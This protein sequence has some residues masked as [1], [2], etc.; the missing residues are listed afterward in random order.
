[1]VFMISK[2][3]L[4]LLFIPMLAACTLS[5][6]S[7]SS[8]NKNTGTITSSN[9]DVSM[10][11]VQNKTSY[12]YGEKINTGKDFDVSIIVG[13]E[14]PYSLSYDQSM[15]DGWY[16]SKLVDSNN[17]SVD[18]L[19]SPLTVAGNYQFTIKCSKYNDLFYEGQFKLL[20]GS[21]TDLAPD[22]ISVTLKRSN[23]NVGDS[24]TK[25]LITVKAT[26]NNY[27]GTETIDYNQDGVNGYAI[28]M[29]GWSFDKPLDEGLYTF[30]VS[31]RKVIKSVSF[32]VGEKELEKTSLIANYVDYTN[33]SVYEIDSMPSVGSPKALIVPVWLTD[34]NKYVSSTQ[35]NQI[36]Q[37]IETAY[38]GSNQDTG[39]RSVK[40]YFQEASYEKL[41]LDGVVTDWYTSTYSSSINGDQT[42]E[43]VKEV[44]NW[45]KRQ[46]SS[47]TYKSFDT[48]E[49]GYLDAL[50]LIYAANN[51]SNGGGNGN[52][53]LWA[54]CYWVQDYNL[55]S[56]ANPGPNTFFWASYDFMYEDTS[57][58]TIDAHTYIHEMGHVL[59]LE[60]Y[61]DYNN[62][63][64]PSGGFI[65]QDYNV[66]DHDPFSK[67]AFGW[68]EP[69]VVSESCVLTINSFAETG[70]VIVLTPEF[71]NSPF[72]E[73]LV[74]D[75][76]TPTGLNE[77]DSKYQYSNGY[78]QG[79]STS[80]IRIWHVD[81]RLLPTTIR[82]YAADDLRTNPN[83]LPSNYL[84]VQLAMSNT[85]YKAGG[86][87]NDYAT[88]ISAFR[89]Y[90][91]LTLLRHNEKTTLHK[92][93]FDANSL[94]KEGDTFS[95][96]EFSSCFA[97]KGKL[98]SGLDLGFSFEITSL[99]AT[100]ATLNI[101][102]I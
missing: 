71:H 102:K 37:D 77:F 14:Q 15:K 16:F 85:Q 49:D 66:G 70:D 36:K 41:N 53:N 98:N 84:G 32:Y 59:G 80:G 73:Y 46:V 11:V 22:S 42:V 88:P 39:W 52:D 72:D 94:W 86:S 101:T 19:T 6:P 21:G 12:L 54:Y 90:N 91:L 45:Y 96:S 5:Y 10:K 43:L 44:A 29:S 57:H 27:G 1:M 68:V 26:W 93:S 50:I 4:I 47:T 34:S 83:D 30:D 17:N 8:T 82:G 97:N 81:A 78:P 100:S 62:V 18:N 69:Y 9:N 3:L 2:K 74:I 58:C 89:N 65:M 76:Y 31:Y 56:V 79:P 55:K 13:N 28:T 75:L 95:M 99:N 33:H 25:D 60:D 35:K 63:D 7:S 23:F 61:Y 51:Y 40:T 67:M 24:F 20:K 87:A 38:L 92:N 64:I 48:D